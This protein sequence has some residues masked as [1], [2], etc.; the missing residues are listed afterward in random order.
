[1]DDIV[2]TFEPF[3]ISG[4]PEGSDIEHS[5]FEKGRKK[6]KGMCNIETCDLP[7][8]LYEEKSRRL[9]G[10]SFSIFP[11]YKNAFQRLVKKIANDNC[12]YVSMSD[13]DKSARYQGFGENDRFEIYWN[14]YEG[15]VVC[16][17]ASLY[18]EGS[19]LYTESDI[20]KDNVTNPFGY[21]VSYVDDIKDTFDLI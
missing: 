8:L 16:E 1:M 3:E 6:V 11:E 2:I 18:V 15:E 12:R 20:K 9:V 13:S 10:F 19:W 14:Y 4:P 17:Y 5:S 7:D 21:W